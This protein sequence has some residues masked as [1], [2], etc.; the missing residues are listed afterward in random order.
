MNAFVLVTEGPVLLAMPKCKTSSSQIHI[1]HHWGGN[2]AY[3]KV[4]YIES[5]VGADCAGAL[6]VKSCHVLLHPVT[7]NN[8]EEL[9]THCHHQLLLQLLLVP[10]PIQTPPLPIILMS[11]HLCLQLLFSLFSFLML[12]ESELGWGQLGVSFPASR[13]GVQQEA[14]YTQGCGAGEQG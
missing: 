2:M 13:P 1:R 5:R 3:S 10:P 6:K 4:V 11:T 14:S 8:G 7:H 12:A 9:E